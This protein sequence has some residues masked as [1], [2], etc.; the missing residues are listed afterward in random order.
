MVGGLNFEDVCS[1]Q[2]FHAMAVMTSEASGAVPT[3]ICP[4]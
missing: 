1:V 2:H 4:G 3:L